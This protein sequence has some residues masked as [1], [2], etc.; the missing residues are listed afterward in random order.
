[1][2]VF[3]VPE[4][5]MSYKYILNR[6]LNA[7]HSSIKMCHDLNLY[8]IVVNSLLY[9]IHCSYTLVINTFSW[10]LILLYMMTIDKF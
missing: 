3:Q 9:I 4:G 5:L 1:M 6:M 7:L 10:S 8:Y 2:I